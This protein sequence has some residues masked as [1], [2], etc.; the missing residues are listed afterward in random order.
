LV[1]QA[2]AGVDL[3]ALVRRVVRVSPGPR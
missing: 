1:G 3:E 2:G